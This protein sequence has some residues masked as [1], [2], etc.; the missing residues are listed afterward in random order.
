MDPFC[1]RS[2][3][4]RHQV[5]KRDTETN[6]ASNFGPTSVLHRAALGA[7]QARE[8]RKEIELKIRRHEEERAKLEK[9]VNKNLFMIRRTDMYRMYRPK[10]ASLPKSHLVLPPPLPGQKDD[11]ARKVYSYNRFRELPPLEGPGPGAE[12]KRREPPPPPGLPKE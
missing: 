3:L 4:Q 10:M 12:P 1:L 7:L 5:T 11:R 2:D 6:R 9:G 8:T